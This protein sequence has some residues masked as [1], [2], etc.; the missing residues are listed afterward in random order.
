MPIATHAIAKPYHYTKHLNL[1]N[2][3]CKCEKILG[4]VSFLPGAL[5]GKNEKAG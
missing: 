5:V 4:A 2:A 3:C 1:C